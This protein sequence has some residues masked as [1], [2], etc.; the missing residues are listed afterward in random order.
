DIVEQDGSDHAGE[1]F[2]QHDDGDDR[3]QDG[4][5]EVVVKAL[6][7]REQRATD[8][9][10]THDPHHGGVAQVGVQLVGGEAH[11][12]GEDLRHDCEDNDVGEGRTASTDGFHLLE[13]D[14]LDCFGEQL[15]DEA[16][17][18]DGKGQ[19]ARQ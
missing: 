2:T 7:G 4:A 3:Q 16:D 19:D 5:D 17:G 18:G 6:E 14:F 9:A 12:A 15:A 1:D 8:T 13:R 11:E 10:C